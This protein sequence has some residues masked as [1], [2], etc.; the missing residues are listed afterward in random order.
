MFKNL[1]DFKYRKSVKQAIGFY[2]IYVL[3]GLLFGF[4]SGFIYG[5]MMANELSLDE[6]QRNAMTIGIYIGSIYTGIMY[7]LAVVKR[8]LKTPII[9]LTGILAIVVAYFLGALA[10]G[11]IVA[12]VTTLANEN[13]KKQIDRNETNTEEVSSIM[14]L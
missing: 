7:Y 6:L 8:K 2:I 10:S 1:F 3:L 14:E 11:I 13:E 5:F 12:I 9:Y 4:L